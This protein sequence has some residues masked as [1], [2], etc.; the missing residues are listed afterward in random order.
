MLKRREGLNPRL[1][2]MHALCRQHQH[3]HRQGK[4]ED[5]YQKPSSLQG[6]IQK[7]AITY[8]NNTILVMTT[9]DLSKVDQG[10]RDR[11][12]LVEMNQSKP[13]DWVSLGQ[14]L[15]K[16]MRLTGDGVDPTTFMNYAKLSQESLGDFGPAVVTLGLSLGG[17]L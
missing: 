13:E 15:F 6:F 16:V 9:N 17:T 1:K 4:G 14:R 8:A 5:E 2:G 7:T 11:S 10:I 3:G 12:V